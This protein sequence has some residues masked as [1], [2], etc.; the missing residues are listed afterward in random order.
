MAQRAPSPDALPAGVDRGAAGLDR[1]L[2]A[3]RTRASLIMVTAHP[4]DEDGG[5]LALRRAAPGPARS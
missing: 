3:L 2:R 1:W 4:D 5:M